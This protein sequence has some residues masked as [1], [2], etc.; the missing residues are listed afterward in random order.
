MIE[1]HS[2]H[3]G[4]T[5]PDVSHVVKAKRSYTSARRSEQARQTRRLVL[6]SAHR[7]F[8]DVGYGATTL[9]RIADEAGVSVQ[10]VYAAFGNKRRVLE[11]TLDLAI[12]GDD[13]PIV[14][15]DRDWMHDVLHHADASVRV[16]AYAAAVRRIHVGAA[17]VFAVLRAA[18]TS[19]PDLRELAD[20]TDARRRTGAGSV[21]DGLISIGALEPSL[22]RAT[23]I[24][25]LWTFNSPELFGLL[26]RRSGW[27]ADQYEQWLADTMCAQLLAVRPTR[28]LP[29][30]PAANR[31]N[32]RDAL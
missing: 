8:V 19:D 28:R 20:T 24:D 26:V 18:A 25:L 29:R 12:A 32:V 9:Q 21:V 4:D 17:D 10:T 16:R 27:S 5:L 11:Q 23:A 7:L 22:D 15:N 6:E 3:C 2:I 30:R 31:G 13:E 1:F 14:V